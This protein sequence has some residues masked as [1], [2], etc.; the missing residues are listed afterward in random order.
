MG[1]LLK[2][3][4]RNVWRNKARSV[5]IILAVGFGLWGG[6]STT[7]FLNGMVTQMIDNGIK[8]QVSHLQI[9]NPEFLKE[10]QSEFVLGSVAEIM[11][12]LDNSDLVQA[13]SPRTLSN[14]MLATASMTSGVEIYGIYADQENSTTSLGGSVIEGDYFTSMAKNQILIGA[15]LAKKMKVAPGNRVVLTFQDLD[16]NITSAAFRIS[17]IYRTSNSMNDERF[18]YV[19]NEDITILKGDNAGINEIAVLLHDI[20]NVNSFRDELKAGFP[21]NEVRS[22][23]EI[24]PD[25]SMMHEMSGISMMILLIIIL[26][27]MAFGLLNT[28][29]MTIFERT[30]EIG[31][32]MAVGMNKLRV[33]MMILLE[34][35]F[36]VFTGSLFGVF[37]GNLTIAV[38]RRTGIDLTSVGG[39]T[40]SDFG[41][42][43]VVYPSLNAEFY[44]NLLIL[45]VI[46]AVLSSIYPA[47]KALRMNPADAIRKD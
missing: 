1:T 29:L 35:G 17:G 3:S 2:I 5:V 30:R 37:L 41:I 20:E 14:G 19:K 18:V 43:P 44:L 31:V 40:F 7:A 36:L 25:L 8:K 16:G 46:T 23:A 26:M 39:D 34:T 38:T 12:E 42:D 27:A 4:W 45:V 33:F 9:H 21:E 47:Y 22:W 6:I 28:M 11:D 15:K 24:S 10:R 32:L 13:Y